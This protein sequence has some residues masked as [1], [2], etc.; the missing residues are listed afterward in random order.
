MVLGEVKKFIVLFL[1]GAL[2]FYEPCLT[3]QR[4]DPEIF[5]G[6]LMTFVLKL[7]FDEGSST[8]Y[9]VCH[10]MCRF[11]TISDEHKLATLM[12]QHAHKLKTA[13][14]NIEPA[15]CLVPPAPNE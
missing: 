8:L 4:L 10:S 2:K 13:Q 6:K 1:L 11:E 3:D 9:K 5:H 7:V 12:S 14:C 15:F